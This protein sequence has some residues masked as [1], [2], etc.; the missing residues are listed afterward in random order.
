MSN[1][2]KIKFKYAYSSSKHGKLTQVGEIIEVESSSSKPSE[3]D[4]VEALKKK[5]GVSDLGLSSSV[6]MWE[7]V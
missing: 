3:R 4:V 7:V 5:M 6:T 2:F 1:K